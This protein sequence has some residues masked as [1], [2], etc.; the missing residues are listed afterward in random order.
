MLST[1]LFLL[2]TAFSQQK[3]KLCSKPHSTKTWLKNLL[4]PLHTRKNENDDDDHDVSLFHYVTLFELRSSPVI[5]C[6]GWKKWMM[7]HEERDFVL[8]RQFNHHSTVANQNIHRV[9]ILFLY[10]RH[11][12]IASDLNDICVVN[13][14]SELSHFSLGKKLGI[15]IIT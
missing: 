10:I 1:K 6:A 2:F 4:S 3:H 7:C 9:H 5:C 12:F 8:S 15:R 11:S 13:S 14:E